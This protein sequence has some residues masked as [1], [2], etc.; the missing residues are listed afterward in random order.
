EVDVALVL[1]TL[2]CLRHQIADVGP[3]LDRIRARWLVVSFPA[4]SLG[5]RE[6]GMVE[7]YRAMFDAIARPR[8]WEAREIV[9]PSELVFVVKR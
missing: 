6:K 9:F 2:P 7:Q 8:G 3:V 4:R 1:K 5:N